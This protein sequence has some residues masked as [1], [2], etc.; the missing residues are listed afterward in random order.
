METHPGDTFRLMWDHLKTMWTPFTAEDNLPFMLF[1]NRF[2]S[3]V[4]W[5]MLLYM[6]PPIFILAALGLI[7][8]LRARW[9]QL[10]IVYASIALTIAQNALFYGNMRFRAPIEPLLVVLAGGVL[11][12]FTSKGA[13]TLRSWYSNR[14]REEQEQP[15]Q[16]AEIV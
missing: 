4:V 15:E 14:R 6:S 12:W 7:L 1:P 3:Q 5:Y 9:R 8:T 2:L 13:G 11:W 10:L 16:L